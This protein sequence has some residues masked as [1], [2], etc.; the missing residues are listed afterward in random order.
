MVRRGG[1]QCRM[2]IYFLL[3]VGRLCL[4]RHSDSHHGERKKEETQR[5]LV[6]QRLE[7]VTT[8][9]KLAGSLL[10]I[11]HPHNRDQREGGMELPL[12]DKSLGREARRPL[13][14]SVTTNNTS[15]WRCRGH[16]L[17]WFYCFVL[18]SA[19]T[20]NS[21]VMLPRPLAKNRLWCSTGPV[22]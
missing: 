18:S 8:K 9:C 7:K 3:R 15:R 19:C 21:P 16:C 12:K 4:A 2:P 17:T 10:P 14:S 13:R 11:A 20:V 1:L 22:F 6:F 5:L